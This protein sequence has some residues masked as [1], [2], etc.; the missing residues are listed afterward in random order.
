MMGRKKISVGLGLG[1]MALAGMTMSCSKSGPEAG[2]GAGP[3]TSIGPISPADT[4]SLKVDGYT[5]APAKECAGFLDRADALPEAGAYNV[6]GWAY[7]PTT[8]TKPSK[9]VIA[10]ADGK[11]LNSVP[12]QVARPD[13]KQTIPGVSVLETGFLARTVIPAHTSV[14][15]FAVMDDG[16][17]ACPLSQEFRQP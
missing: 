16:K 15:A 9:V 1:V 4:A 7:L 2:A 13:V 12:L 3:A 11:V 6:A 8:N 17:T 5:L 14:R 10:S